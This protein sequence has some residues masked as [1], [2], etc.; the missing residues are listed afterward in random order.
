M[1]YT[2]DAVMICKACALIILFNAFGVQG[3]LC[4][5]CPCFFFTIFLCTVAKKL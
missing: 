2:A 1:I 4:D 5:K 3:H